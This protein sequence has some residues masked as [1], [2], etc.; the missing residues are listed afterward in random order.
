[1]GENDVSVTVSL[2]VRWQNA[3]KLNSGNLAD[4]LPVNMLDHS[5]TDLIP[6]PI[7]ATYQ[8]LQE[9]KTA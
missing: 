2:I 7:N 5:Q 9:T 3:Q 6:S 8:F 4:L 1:M